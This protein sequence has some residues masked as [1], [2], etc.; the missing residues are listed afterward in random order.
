MKRRSCPLCLSRIH[1]LQREELEIVLLIEPTAF[2]NFQWQAG[3]ASEGEGIDRE[4]H[5]GVS[6]FPRVWLV[7]EDVDVSVA[8]L[9]EVDVSSDNVGLEVQVEVAA[10]IV[11]NVVSHEIDRN[12]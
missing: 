2:E 5:V 10:S 1:S 3:S 11:G 6:L 4:L 7:V 9:Q 8:D 12:L